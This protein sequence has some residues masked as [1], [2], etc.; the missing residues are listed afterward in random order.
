MRALLPTFRL[1][2]LPV[3]VCCA[4]L[5][6]PLLAESQAGQEP[7]YE[8]TWVTLGILAV[9]LALGALVKA[10]VSRRQPPD[11]GVEP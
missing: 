4:G 9:I 1:I 8:K 5:A 11:E 3:F 2:L 7:S 10:K 6:A